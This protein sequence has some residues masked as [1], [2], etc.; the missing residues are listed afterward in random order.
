[1][2]FILREN[3]KTGMRLGRPIYSKDGTLLYN[4]GSRLTEQGI[5]SVNNFG[6][7]GLYILEEAEPVPILSD[8][9]IDLERFLIAGTTK[10]YID[11]EK[12]RSGMIPIYLPSLVSEIVSKYGDLDHKI[13]FFQTI[14]SSEDK[15]YKHCL[16]MAILCA[17]ICSRMGKRRSE[18]NTCV[19]TALLHD[20]GWL[21]IPK[22]LR[23]KT[24]VELTEE[25]KKSLSVEE[26]KSLQ[27]LETKANNLPAI[28]QLMGQHFRMR[29]ME[30]FGRLDP[31]TRSYS[32]ATKIL[33]VACAFDRL[34]SMDI[35]KEPVTELSAVRIMR[36]DTDLFD[37]PVLNALI[38]S[39][40]VLVSGCSVKL[41]NG[42]SG[43]VIKENPF[44]MAKPVVLLFDNNEMLDLSDV[45][46][47]GTLAVDD[48]VKTLDNRW[49]IDRAFIDAYMASLKRKK[50]R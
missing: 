1:M 36:K 34:T 39:V 33:T 9:E 28:R 30:R 42:L 43:C 14:R 18:M 23:D 4:V 15:R 48:V 35:G 20:I 24:D 12:I 44:Y 25:E 27:Y 46:K 41:T 49:V 5:I 2:K 3:L 6:V 50:Q 13:S 16:S 47:H 40:N 10:L 31:E 29:R 7:I 26:Y 17:M 22:E 8:E 45:K 38:D 19:T 32:D 11:W 21:D 37:T